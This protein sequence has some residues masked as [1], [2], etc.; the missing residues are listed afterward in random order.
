MMMM[1]IMGY[2]EVDEV[3]V[4][5]DVAMCKCKMIVMILKLRN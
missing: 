5:I 4:G 3:E 1:K 2:D